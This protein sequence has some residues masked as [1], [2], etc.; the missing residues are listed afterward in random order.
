MVEMSP[1]GDGV[2]QQG[3][4]GDVFNTAWY[5]RKRMSED[6]RVSFYSRVGSDALSDRFV[7]FTKAHG[8][9]PSM[10]R[11]DPDRTMGLYLIELNEGERS[12]VYWRKHSAARML[13]ADPQELEH[14]VT[15]CDLVYFSG[16]TLAILSEPDRKTLVETLEAARKLGKQVA[17]DPNIRP[18]L[19]QSAAEMR[20]WIEAGA[21][22][23]D[24]ILPSFEDEQTAFG[25]T[26]P[27]ATARRY[28]ALGGGLVI[29]KNGGGDVT[30]LET[31][32]APVIR[33]PVRQVQQV[34]DT[35]AAG[36]SFN[37]AFLAAW[38]NGE[39]LETSV[40]QAADNAAEVIGSFGALA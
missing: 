1:R 37:G 30:C 23:A 14:A 31:P 20:H 35:T 9:D 11:R 19:W 4:A 39:P 29:V 5:A 16:I 27:E 18:R 32:N 12:F 17:F 34:R 15:G 40:H 6:W 13:A 38:G 24:I 36:D 28:S 22:I 26:D 25:D 21:R 8:I 7:E 10:I 33:V 2:F 3:F